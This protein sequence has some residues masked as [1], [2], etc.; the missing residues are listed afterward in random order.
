MGLKEDMC[1]NVTPKNPKP[2]VALGIGLHSELPLSRGSIYTAIMELGPKNHD[3][4]VLLGPNCILVMYMDPL[5]YQ[6]V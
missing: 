5:G 4:D 2:S 6:V 1:P 3:G